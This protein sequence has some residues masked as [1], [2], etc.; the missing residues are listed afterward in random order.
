[1]PS[2][3]IANRDLS[4]LIVSS[5]DDYHSVLLLGAVS[6]FWHRSSK[7]TRN[8]I[9]R[10]FEMIRWMKR[11]QMA[12]YYGQSVTCDAR[13]TVYQ[14][15]AVGEFAWFIE[16]DRRGGQWTGF[17]MMDPLK[18]AVF[19]ASR[20]RDRE[21]DGPS[22]VQ[23]FKGARDFVWHLDQLRGQIAV[24]DFPRA[25]QMGSNHTVA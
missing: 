16:I 13:L 5:C 3:V 7:K 24:Y 17:V 15:P 18:G 21:L 14:A 20:E 22:A 10:S 2:E 9:M 19:V 12:G 25:C 4:L 23:A 6:K 8:Q 1:M 11:V